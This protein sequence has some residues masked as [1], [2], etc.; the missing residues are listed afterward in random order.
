MQRRVMSPSIR[1]PTSTLPL[2]LCQVIV[3]EQLGHR[4]FELL[5]VLVGV[6][7][8]RDGGRYS[9]GSTRSSDT[10]ARPTPSIAARTK[11]STSSTI[12]GP[13][14]AT[15][16]DFLPLSNSH[17]YTPADPCR[18]LMH[19]CLSRSWGV[20]GLGCDLKYEGAPTMAA[21]WSLDT[22]TAIMSF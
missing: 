19:R 14:T 4:L 10:K 8:V 2:T 16:R 22:R 21:R 15:D 7:G 12:R 5:I 1:Q 20:F 17:R 6:I 9:S 11:V 18:K 13:F 3:P